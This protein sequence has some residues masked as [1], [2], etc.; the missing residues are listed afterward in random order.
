MTAP[1]APTEVLLRVF[2]LA[3]HQLRNLSAYVH[4]KPADVVIFYGLCLERLRI[5]CATMG[6]SLAVAPS[7]T[8]SSHLPLVPPECNATQRLFL[9]RLCIDLLIALR[10]KK[11][12]DARQVQAYV[13]LVSMLLKM[14]ENIPSG[15]TTQYP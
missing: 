10:K 8:E 6:F 14:S 9:R 3:L 4:P 2:V 7:L 11:G 1:S 12:F 5:F 13:Q 15:A